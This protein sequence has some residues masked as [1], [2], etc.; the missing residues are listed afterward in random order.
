MKTPKRKKAIA[1]LLLLAHIAPWFIPFSVRLEASGASAPELEQMSSA[2]NTELVNLFNGSFQYQIPLMEVGGFPLT[3]SY[4]STVSMESEASMVG[5]GWTLNT[6]AISRSVRGLPDDFDG[7][8][9]STTLSAKPDET[10]GFGVGLGVELVGLERDAGGEETGAEVSGGVD[11]S[12]SAEYNTYSGWSAGFGALA[13]IGGNTGGD[14]KSNARLKVGIASN[15]E[16]GTTVNTDVSAGFKSKL[17]ADETIQG[18]ASYGLNVHSRQGM[19]QQ[20]LNVQAK[21]VNSKLWEGQGGLLGAIRNLTHGQYGAGGRFNLAHSSPSMTPSIGSPMIEEGFEGN[22]KIGGELGG[23]TTLS[24]DLEFSYNKKRNAKNL[25]NIPCFGYMYAQNSAGGRELLDVLREKG[26]AFSKETPN[27]PMSQFAYDVYNCSAPGLQTEFRPFR[28]D[29]GTLHDPSTS[30]MS[31]TGGIGAEIGVGDLTKVGVNIEVPIA[32]GWSGKWREGNAFNSIFQFRK[33]NPSLPLYEPVYFKSMGEA[34]AMENPQQ[35]SQLGAFSAVKYSVNGDGNSGSA[36]SASGEGPLTLNGSNVLRNKREFRQNVFQWLTAREASTAAQTREIN[37]YPLN[38]FQTPSTAVA[39]SSSIA[40]FPRM[41]TTRNAGHIS[42]V[43]VTRTDGSRCVFGVPA[44]SNASTD[45][46]FNISKK[47]DEEK[48][49][50]NK[51]TGLIQYTSGEDNSAANNRGENHLYQSERT[52]A[53]VYAWLLSEMQSPDYVDITGNGP[54][55][56]DL[57]SYTKINYTQARNQ[58]YWRLPLQK[59]SAYFDSNEKTNDQD[60]IAHYS[61]GSREQWYVHS[62]ETK[63]YVAEFVYS[64]RD[65]AV[66]VQG[67]N[68]GLNPAMRLLKLDK[69]TLYTKASRLSAQPEPIKVVHF[70]Y[71]YSLCGHLPSNINGQGKLTLKALWFEEGSSEKGS[72]T[73][74]IFSYSTFNPDYNSKNVDRW[75]SYIAAEDG[76]S[77][78][79]LKSYSALSRTTAD[80]FAS[81]W[82][83]TAIKTPSGAI[84][85]VDYE[86]NDYA[87]VQDKAAMEM[88]QIVGMRSHDGRREVVSATSE[89]ATA[90]LLDSDAKPKNYLQFKLKDALRSD[91]DLRRY[92]ENIQELY[93]SASVRIGKPTLN[94]FEKI[95]GFI[96]VHLDVAGRDFGLCSNPEY[97]WLRLPQIHNGDEQ[98][99]LGTFDTDNST[100]GGVHPLSKMAW[101]SIRKKYMHLVYNNPPD[102]HNPEGFGAAL[103]NCFAVLGEFF[104]QA[105]DYLKNRGH[106]NVMKLK[107][108]KLRLQSPDRVKL[109]GGTRVRRVMLSDQWG[110][111]IQ[112]SAQNFVYAKEYIYRIQEGDRSISSGVAQYEP[113]VGN[114][115]NP[116]VVPYRYVIEKCMS[117]NQNLYQTGPLGQIYFPGADIGYRKVTIRS[118]EGSAGPREGYSVYEY[119]TAKDYPTIVHSTPIT[120]ATRQMKVGEFYSEEILNATQ[121]FSVELNDMHGKPKAQYSY[122]PDGTTPS[123]GVVYRYSS[124]SSDATMLQN[125]VLTVDPLSGDTATEYVGV[126]YEVFSDAREHNQHSFHPSAAV[127]LD[128]S[129]RG[130]APVII[131]SVY[132]NYKHQYQLMRLGT[133]N[134]VIYRCGLLQEIDAF[135][136][137]AIVQTKN[138]VRDRESGEVVVSS[139]K[140]AYADP[141]YKLAY[142]ARWIQ[143]NKGMR[144]AYKNVGLRAQGVS[145]RA[146]ALRLS[147]APQSQLFQQGDELLCTVPNGAAPTFRDGVD[148]GRT[149]SVFHA[150]VMN[151]DEGADITYLIGRNGETIG[152]GVYSIRVLRSGYRNLIDAHA[153]EYSLLSS[154]FQSTKLTIPNTNVLSASVNEFSN[155]WQCYGLFESTVPQYSCSCSPAEIQ[156]RSAVEL[157]GEFVKTLL[158]RGDNERS[159]VRITASYSPGAAFVTQRFGTRTAVLYGGQ[160]SGSSSRGFLSSASDPSEQCELN[161]RMADG[162]TMFPDSIVSFTIDQR[163]FNDGDGDCNDIFTVGGTIEYMGQPI[164]ERSLQGQNP[165]QRRSARVVISTCT[166]LANCASVQTRAGEIRCLGA[167]RMII[168]PFVHGVLGSWRPKADWSFATTRADEFNSRKGAVL[169]AYSDFFSAFPLRVKAPSERSARWVKQTEAIVHDNTGKT[170]DSRSVLDAFSTKLF[171]YNL[172]LPI[173]EADYARHS[174]IAFDGFEDYNFTNQLSNPFSSCP[175][176]QHFKPSEFD[177]LDQTQSHTGRYS[178]PVRSNT[179]ITRSLVNQSVGP[180]AAI[181]GRRFAADS[182]IVI[183]P[184]SPAPGRYLLSVWVKKTEG[185]SSTSSSPSTLERVSKLLLPGST[186]VPRLGEVLRSSRAADVEVSCRKRGG[187]STSLA[188]LQCSGVPVDDWYLVQGE[189]T[190]PSDAV[191]VSVELKS[192]SGTTWFDDLRVQPYHARMKSYVYD[193]HS[194]R[195]VAELDENNFSTRYVYDAQGS[196]VAKKRETERG[197]FTVQ[198]VRKGKS[199]ISGGR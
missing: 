179:S 173:A 48:L 154:P 12:L 144:G 34:V 35:F 196:M 120:V 51:Q 149:D 22:L 77:E 69:I 21:Y 145:V 46:S 65:D 58:Y 67:E 16:S 84:Q 115:E 182:S 124:D 68:G 143:E 177:A 98:R 116:F 50:R 85:S 163:Q 9:I 40:R 97:A 81:A 176:P 131:P 153:G 96:P 99:D 93:L 92:V 27:L 114:E 1:A 5:L 169:D 172:S 39:F 199:K 86:S 59:D 128:I 130:P 117:I 2:E 44:Y 183:S 168:N 31:S 187:A 159:A 100:T 170:L 42:E 64:E 132:P 87:Y 38:V 127:N 157:L 191:S 28:G 137:G 184:F 10:I 82:R 94:E 56:D 197:I 103:E 192:A 121:G 73:P 142:P 147:G 174:D 62:I 101:E 122:P 161:I 55:S 189:F 54:S 43:I 155:Y 140:N 79:G 193:P 19:K 165:R 23:T 29:V 107:G 150:W 4:S 66:G 166:P 198:E 110:A 119:Y 60:D 136:H 45:V 91:E 75:G 175:L 17:N 41:S 57:G 106:A 14:F 123:S 15:S 160:R 126:D 32:S 139:T 171:G 52:P 167:G 129:I 156:K 164:V 113:R 151:V 102:P 25:E 181:N 152:D 180:T 105:N 194:L 80:R 95:E 109:G 146:G 53:H 195:L 178:L 11:A 72:H 89:D 108:A 13:N 148:Y 188:T 37:S 33:H 7:D 24:G 8:V 78:D 83:L 30:S 118:I 111:M 90:E 6:G 158:L 74:Y 141:V 125:R 112:D 26:N 190:L 47:A 185:S 76:E 61:Y 138:L 63:N 36:V 49:R 135:D 71:D 186:L 18:S 20:G 104:V 162:S 3:L 88:L 133:V 70:V 134:K